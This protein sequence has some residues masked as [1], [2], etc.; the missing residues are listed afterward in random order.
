MFYCDCSY[1]STQIFSNKIST[2]AS[3][4]SEEDYSFE[5]FGNVLTLDIY[6]KH[7]NPKLCK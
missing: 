3:E 6:Y 2:A 1:P 7:Q 5:S 4:S